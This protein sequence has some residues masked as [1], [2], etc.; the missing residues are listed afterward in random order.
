METIY[1]ELATR[2][3]LGQSDRIAKLFQII[4]DPKEAQLLLALPG[5]PPEVAQKLNL[6]ES[7][8]SSMLHTLFIKG[9]VF[10]SG[11]SDPPKYQNVS[12]P[13]SVP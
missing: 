8:V 12:G 6:T 1:S 4:A 5:T 3:G 9:V 10:P 13:Y 11:K 7:E 2:I